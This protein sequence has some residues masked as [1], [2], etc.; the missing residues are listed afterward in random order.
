MV[1]FEKNSCC[2]IIYLQSWGETRKNKSYAW[3][4][5]DR[6]IK[7]FPLL[8]KDFF[9]KGQQI[10]S[11]LISEVWIS[12]FGFSSERNWRWV[13]LVLILNSRL[14]ENMKLWPSQVSLLCWE[15]PGE[16]L[17]VQQLCCICSYVYVLCIPSLGRPRQKWI[18][19]GRME[20]KEG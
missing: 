2:L 3:N 4:R 5:T 6:W 20:K 1:T 15:P 12:E 16:F 8:P 17:W 19:F 11:W 18:V 14:C 10:R 13:P 7:I 9:L